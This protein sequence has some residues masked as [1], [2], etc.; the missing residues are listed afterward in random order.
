MTIP[1][2]N[3][4]TFLSRVYRLGDNAIERGKMKSFFLGLGDAT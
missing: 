4:D 1:P 3:S 2:T